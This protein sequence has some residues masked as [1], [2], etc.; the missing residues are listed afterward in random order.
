MHQHGWYKIEQH[1]QVI[2]VRFYSTWNKE[3]AQKMCDDFLKVAKTIADKPWA[4]LVDLSEWGL[5]GPEVWQPII[6]VNHWCNQNN[7]KLEAVVCSIA[8]QEHILRNLQQALP[9]T[10]PEFFSTEVDAK[11]WLENKGYPF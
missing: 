2:I 8:I 6:E 7:Q 4:C 3:T 10:E 9:N 5:G 1:R 11:E